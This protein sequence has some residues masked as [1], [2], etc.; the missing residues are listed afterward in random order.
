MSNEY[1]P[2]VTV[3]EACKM[4]RPLQPMPDNDFTL[5]EKVIAYNRLIEF[6]ELLLPKE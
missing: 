5:E 1:K 3:D 4:V 2:P 6:F